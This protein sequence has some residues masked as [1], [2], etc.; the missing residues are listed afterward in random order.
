[1]AIESKIISPNG[2][3]TSHDYEFSKQLF[4]RNLHRDYYLSKCCYCAIGIQSVKRRLCRAFPSRFI[5]P[6][7][8]VQ[9]ASLD[10]RTA[11]V[12]DRHHKFSGFTDIGE[13]ICTRLI[14]ERE[15]PGFAVTLLFKPSLRFDT[16]PN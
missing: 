13:S 16:Y 6:K 7:Q 1:M 5:P 14:S 3:F 4:R 8:R 12:G 11:H 15:L 2:N 9:E 10:K